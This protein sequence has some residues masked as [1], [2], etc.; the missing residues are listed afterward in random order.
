MSENIKVLIDRSDLVGIANT[1]RNKTGSNSQMTFGEFTTNISGITGV[2]LPSLDNPATNAEVFEG[3]EV[4]DGKGQKQT[5]TFTIDE[6]LTDQSDLISQISTLVATKANPSGGGTGEDVTT[7]TNAYTTKIASLETAV[8]ALENELAGKASG[9]GS[10]EPQMI[11]ITI[12]NSYIP[13]YYFD[14][15]STLQEAPLNGT[16]SALNGIVFVV[17]SAPLMCEGNFTTK[18]LNTSYG[19]GY[20]Q[21][22]IFFE[23]GG[24]AYV[25]YGGGAGI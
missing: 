22:A 23:N 14:S 4:I 7:E 19:G 1:I 6:E 3:Y 9:G 17:T 8:T 20:Y 15:S 2:E 25:A 13:I 11:D 10:G 5:G 12:Q 24:I 18:N 16:I 21:S